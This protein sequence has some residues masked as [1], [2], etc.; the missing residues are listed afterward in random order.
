MKF[1]KN[2]A[3]AFL[4]V[5]LFTTVIAQ[6]KCLITVKVDKPTAEIQPTM[7]GVFFED[8]NM[9]ADGGI[10]AELVKNR[11]FEFYK[12]MMGWTVLQKQFTEG[13]IQVLNRQEKNT[14]NP[15]F[16]R[17]NANQ[18]SKGSLG[19]TSSHCRRVFNY[20]RRMRN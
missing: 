5:G 1:I 3:T 9:G 7:W 18:S 16:I 10:Y 4:C 13:A 19:L 6:E 17:I 12:P 8:I 2:L 20:R 14:A 15:R 11:S